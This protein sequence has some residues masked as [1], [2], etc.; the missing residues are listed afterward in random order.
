MHMHRNDIAREAVR[1]AR[2]T[3]RVPDTIKVNSVSVRLERV[4]SQEGIQAI[5]CATL[6]ARGCHEL[7]TN[8]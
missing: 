1:I 8:K 4:F 7:R 2:K 6:H 3:G 5:S